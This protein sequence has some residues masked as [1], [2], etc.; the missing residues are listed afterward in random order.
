M[1]ERKVLNK[2]YPAEFDPSKIKMV[3]KPKINHQVKSRM[4]LPMSI[5]CNTCGNYIYKGTKF[6]S[7][8]EEAIAHKYLSIPV[9]RF[10]FKC[11]CCSAELSI[12]TDPR[13]SDYIVESG[14]TR[15]FE[16]W[17]AQDEETDNAKRRRDSEEKGDP[18]KALENRTLDSKR[19]MDNL[20]DLDEL[21]SIN[22]RHATVSLDAT[23]A[24]LANTSA[25]EDKED[26]FLAKSIFNSPKQVIKRISDDS[27]SNRESSSNGLKKKRKLSESA[28]IINVVKKHV[29]S[30]SNNSPGR[31]ETK[32][33]E[34]KKP[35]H[36]TT[37]L[38]SLFQIYDSDEDDDD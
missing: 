38:Q 24:A 1:G 28:V 16:P 33:E 26:E 11:T 37:S 30:S 6:N 10:Y 12:R 2:Y 23:L 7:R 25:D 27:S 20:A 13:N 36:A 22:S 32:P 15:N 31:K 14:A 5:R 4:M 35:N 9:F 8:K 29:A 21:M 19:L 3:R 17:R 18:L 34:H